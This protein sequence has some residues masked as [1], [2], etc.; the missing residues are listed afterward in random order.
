[1]CIALTSCGGGGSS[2]PPST[3]GTTAE[4]PAET[5]ESPPAE[6]SEAAGG[7]T[8][9]G[10][11]LKVGEAA[12]V[13]WVPPGSFEPAK[14][15]AGVELGVTVTAIEEG[16]TGDLKNI[17]LE[18]DDEGAVPFYVRLKLEAPMSASVPAEEDPAYSF[19]A[20]DDRHQ[21]QPSVTFLGEFAP[22][23]DVAVPHPFSGGVSYETC[24]TYLMQGGGSIEEVRWD[25]GPAKANEV[26]AYFEHP[27]V[28]TAGA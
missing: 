21:E 3:A 25:S 10:A 4:A 9:P 13:A 2:S 17:E 27:I 8:A 16:S 5:S 23:E 18:P 20:I 28:W 6:T 15:Q 19:T 1:V 22:C 12:S 14:T 7:L 11:R 26:T 24:L